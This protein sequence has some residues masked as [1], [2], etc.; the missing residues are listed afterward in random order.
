MD[1]ILA[2]ATGIATATILLGCSTSIQR[3]SDAEAVKG[4]G[5]LEAKTVTRDEVQGRTGA[6]VASYE[7]G[8]I[9]TYRLSRRDG[10]FARGPQD[11]PFT[12]VVVYRP[13]DVVER[14]SLVN[15]QHEE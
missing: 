7:N 4:L 13:D 9:A 11:A 5:F 14:W 1:R 2:L 15:R 12:L 6:P 3:V 10:Q 8:R